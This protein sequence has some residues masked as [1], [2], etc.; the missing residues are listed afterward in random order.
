MR[1]NKAIATFVVALLILSLAVPGAF[2][3][4]FVAD[5]AQPLPEKAVE[6]A[7][8]VSHS[9]DEAPNPDNLPD[10]ALS[11]VEDPPVDGKAT[12]AKAKSLKG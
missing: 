9:A 4:D 2:A 1:T 7:D 10:G 12:A 8:E 11:L 3:L 6:A 5:E